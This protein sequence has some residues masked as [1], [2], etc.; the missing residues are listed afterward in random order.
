MQFLENVQKKETNT[1]G[2]L[3]QN[4]VRIT[5]EGNVISTMTGVRGF[6]FDLAP[7]S[8]LNA[9]NLVLAQISHRDVVHSRIAT[10]SL[11]TLYKTDIHH[12]T[13]VSD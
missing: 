11:F 7:K 6:D 13:A 5:I 10:V 3:Q 8:L 12:S 2:W 1:S 9:H 4:G